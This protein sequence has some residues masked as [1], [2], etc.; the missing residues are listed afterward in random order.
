LGAIEKNPGEIGFEIRHVPAL[1]PKRRRWGK[2][3]ARGERT[4]S[5]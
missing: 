2:R 1:Y 5:V 4:V 3:L